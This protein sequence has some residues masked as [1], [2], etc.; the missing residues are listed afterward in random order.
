MY[1]DSLCY[2]KVKRAFCLRFLSTMKCTSF[3]VT[4]RLCIQWVYENC[5]CSIAKQ[6]RHVY[7]NT[8]DWINIPI[9]S[10]HTHS[11]THTRHF[12]RLYSGAFNSA[13]QLHDKIIPEERKGN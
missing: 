12:E 1:L 11:H 10:P 9:K 13:V 4:M 5:L 7:I 2:V 6:I 3:D 8:Y